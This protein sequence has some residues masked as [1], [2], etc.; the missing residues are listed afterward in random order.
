MAITLQP[1][2]I[3][4]IITRKKFMRAKKTIMYQKCVFGKIF[5]SIETNGFVLFRNITHTH[6]SQYS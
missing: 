4:K 1:N 3:H 2:K 5:F 6:N